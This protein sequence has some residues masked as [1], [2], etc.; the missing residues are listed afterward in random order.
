MRVEKIVPREYD[1]DII[2]LVKNNSITMVTGWFYISIF[3]A[4]IGVLL[5]ILDSAIENSRGREPSHDIHRASR[6]NVCELSISVDMDTI[7]ENEV[8]CLVHCE[9]INNCGILL[10]NLNLYVCANALTKGKDVVWDQTNVYLGN[11]PE[12]DDRIIDVPLKVPSRTITSFT[13]L[14]SGNEIEDLNASTAAVD[15]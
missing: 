12:G 3:C 10:K 6:H 1:T 15:T 11:F 5:L 2:M 9:I 4:S 14:V 7:S 13:A 8:K